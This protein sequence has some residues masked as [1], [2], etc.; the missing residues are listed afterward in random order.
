MSRYECHITLNKPKS[1]E[2]ARK[3]FSI[4]ANHNMKTSFIAG[5]PVLGSGKYFYLNGFDISFDLLKQ[6]MELAVALIRN[7]NIEV[8]REKIEQ[9]LHDTKT[10]YFE[11]G[12]NCTACL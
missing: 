12:V 4:A 9:I 7:H 6:R 2:E 10:N 1:T 8:L 5:D 11:C 3:L